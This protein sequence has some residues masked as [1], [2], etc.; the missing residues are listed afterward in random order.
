MTYF[1]YSQFKEREKVTK[2]PVQSIRIDQIRAHSEKSYTYPLL[3]RA[4]ALVAA[5]GDYQQAFSWLAKHPPL[6][7]SCL[8]PPSGTSLSARID[9]GTSCTL[10]GSSLSVFHL[11]LHLEL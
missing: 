3:N 6:Q 10:T 8:Y 7:A 4:V 1:D 2:T 9:S 11:E 5:I